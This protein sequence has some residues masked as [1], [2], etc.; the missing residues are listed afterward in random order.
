[1]SGGSLNNRLWNTPLES[2][3]WDEKIRWA[4]DAAEGMAFIHK[5]GFVH[6][7]LKTQNLLYDKETGTCK[8]KP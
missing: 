1:M 5:R 7:D 2:V 4:L 6:R 8:A 3:S